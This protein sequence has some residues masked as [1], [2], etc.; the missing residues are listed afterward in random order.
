MNESSVK[1]TKPEEHLN[2]VVRC[3]LRPLGDGL[4]ALKIHRN[5]FRADD[6]TQ[7]FQ[8]VGILTALGGVDEEFRL[9]KAGQH[10]AHVLCM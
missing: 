4:D 8:R 5:P 9:F 6:K 7:K 1:V 2:V 10:S 3:R